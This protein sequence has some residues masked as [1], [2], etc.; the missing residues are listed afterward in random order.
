MTKRPGGRARLREGSPPRGERMRGGGGQAKMRQGGQAAETSVPSASFPVIDGATGASGAARVGGVELFLGC[1]FSGKTTRM[2]RRILSCAPA[3]AIAIK[4]A[5][6]TRCQADVIVSHAGLSVPARI[7]AEAAELS[8]AV[9]DANVI[10]IDEAHFFDAALPDVCRRLADAGVTV[11]L[12]GLDRTSWGRPFPVIEALREIADGV[13]RLTATCARCGAVA[14]HTQRLTPVVE[15]R[16]VGGSEAFEP[17][18]AA[19]WR[20]PPEAPVDRV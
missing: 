14:E 17:R 2:L 5:Q 1:M 19:C 7:V 10:G 20:P 13:I 16:I 18:C 4:H 3:R 12:T 6:D 8:G 9:G 11:M 15:G